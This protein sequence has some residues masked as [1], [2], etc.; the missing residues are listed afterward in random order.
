MIIKKSNFNFS[1]KKYRGKW[2]FT[3]DQV[4][5]LKTKVEEYDAFGI[6]H[7]FGAFALSGILESYGFAKLEEAGIW[8]DNPEIPGTKKSLTPVFEYL[9]NLK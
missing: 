9:E 7:N 2:P 4:A 3:V 6:I 8:A 1:G 5:I